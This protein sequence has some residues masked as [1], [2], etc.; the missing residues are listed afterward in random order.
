[1]DPKQLSTLLHISPK[2]AEYILSGKRT[3][4]RN[5]A[6]RFESI[7]GIDRRAWI[8]TDSRIS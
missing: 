3:P 7:T 2:Y 8:K 5:A 4:S 6:V 1:M